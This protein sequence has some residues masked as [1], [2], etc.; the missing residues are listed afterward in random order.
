MINF[1]INFV[2]K[3]LVILLVILLF[4]I[5]LSLSF[6]SVRR[7]MYGG[8]ATTLTT[9]SFAIMH[10]AGLGFNA[11][12]EAFVKV[13]YSLSR[14]IDEL[15]SLLVGNRILT[16]LVS[17]ESD[18]LNGQ[19]CLYDTFTAY[20]ISYLF[21]RINR[22]FLEIKVEFTNKI[23]SLKTVLLK[24]INL[25]KYTFAYRLWD[26]LVFQENKYKRWI[27]CVE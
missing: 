5:L 3:N 14:Q 16:Q 11:F 4:V 17:L 2:Q 24:K 25:S 7:I 26:Y 22:Y 1:V 18:C 20:N 27:I 8:V 21:V 10:K 15:Q 12:Y 23:R 9:V 6:E 13:I 19:F